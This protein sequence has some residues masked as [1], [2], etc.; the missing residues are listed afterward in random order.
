MTT[1]L[2]GVTDDSGPSVL[3]SRRSGS[4][5]TLE[6]SNLLHSEIYNCPSVDR[7]SRPLEADFGLPLES[8]AS[9]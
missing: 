4:D 3:I 6:R 1:S 8:D 9:K 5:D 2:F 7:D